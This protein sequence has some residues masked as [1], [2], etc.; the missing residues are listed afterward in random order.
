M[1]VEDVLRL[2]E[3]EN[4]IKN[5]CPFLLSRLRYELVKSFRPRIRKYSQN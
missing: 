5:A 3:K 2:K 1:I 4:K